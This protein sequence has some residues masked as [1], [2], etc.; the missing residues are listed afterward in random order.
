EISIYSSVGLAPVHIAFLFMAEACVYAIV[1]AVLGYLLGQVVATALVHFGWLA[2]LTLNYS[3]MSTVVATV[4]VMIVVLGST[5][6][7]AIKA[8]RMAVPDIERKWKL[9]EPDGD[10]WHFD[11]PFTVLSE[12]A[13]GLNIFMRDYFEAHADESASDFYTD[14]VTF[15]RA[16]DPPPSSPHLGEGQGV[17]GTDV[18]S[19]EGRSEEAYSIGMMVWLAPYDLG[20]SQSIQLMTSQVGGEE[21]ELYKITLDVHRESGEIASWK[22][23]NRRF[24]NLI[25]KQ[26]LI[27]RTFSAEVRGEFHERGREEREAQAV[28][29]VADLVPQPA[30]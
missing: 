5:L 30:D 17:R 12:E 24:L 18:A 16:T 4:V 6:Y 27:W 9:S 2:G 3:S 29:G 23:V 10:E 1:G 20:V 11:L 14:Q 15:S 21:E 22:R 28:P 25:R 26:L 19:A 8:S 7:P 13:L